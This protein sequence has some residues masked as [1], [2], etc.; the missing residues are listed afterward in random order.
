MIDSSDVSASDRYHAGVALRLTRPCRPSRRGGVLVQPT[1]GQ[2][3]AKPRASRMQ[4]MTDS[5]RYGIP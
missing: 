2:F 5:P 3:E 1:V 4:A